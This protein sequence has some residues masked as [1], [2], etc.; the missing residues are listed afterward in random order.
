MKLINSRTYL[1]LLGVAAF[2][3]LGAG[4]DTVE[5]LGEDIEELGDEIE[6]EADDAR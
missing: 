2:S 1:T 3:I 4:C 5:G 6:D